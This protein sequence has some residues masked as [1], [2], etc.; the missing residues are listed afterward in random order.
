MEEAV[1]ETPRDVKTALGHLGLTIE[2]LQVA[3]QAGYYAYISRTAN[4]A[5]SAAGYYQWNDT[6]RALREL[7]VPDGWTRHDQKGF[8]TILNPGKTIALC[9]YSGNENTGRPGRPLSTKNAKGPCTEHLVESNAL[10]LFDLAP[11][12]EP[13]RLSRDGGTIPTWALVFYN[14]AR[15]IRS[16][17]ALPVFIK[18]GRIEHWAK[19]IILPAIPHEPDDYKRI[20]EPDFG[21]DIDIDIRR[22][23]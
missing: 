14:D 13:V 20:I 11:A 2:P 18:D 23:A 19:R 1:W 21:P 10:T 15:E 4:D 7:Y 17:I 8:P 12:P 9:V 3:V 5:P 22:R 16:E 6:I